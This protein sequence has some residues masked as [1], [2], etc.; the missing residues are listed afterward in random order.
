MKGISHERTV[1]K[2]PPRDLRGFAEHSVWECIHHFVFNL[3]RT[4]R[5]IPLPVRNIPLLVFGTTAC[6][7]FA[8]LI[9]RDP[10][11]GKYL[12]AEGMLFKERSARARMTSWTHQQGWKIPSQK[13]FREHLLECSE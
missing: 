9:T 7:Y 6:I 11:G 4:Y 8:E 1:V 10:V 5:N 13:C 12:L 3:A 2:I